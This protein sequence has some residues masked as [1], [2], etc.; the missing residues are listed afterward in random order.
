M[1]TTRIKD[2]HCAAAIQAFTGF[3]PIQLD[4]VE[5]VFWFVFEG[6]IEVENLI[7][8]Y[9]DGQLIGSFIKFSDAIHSLK[10]RMYANR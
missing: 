1:K 9:W 10:K 3:A 6:N 4:E 2:L 8:A 7:N 5:G